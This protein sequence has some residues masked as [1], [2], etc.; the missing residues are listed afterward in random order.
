MLELE[1]KYV[2]LTA[3]PDDEIIFFGAALPYIKKIICCSNNYLDLSG[4]K[5]KQ[6]NSALKEIGQIIKTEIVCLDYDRNFYKLSTFHNGLYNFSQ[7]VLQLIKKEKI[8]FTHNFWG[9]YGNFDHIFIH[10]LAKTTCRKIITTDTCINAQIGEGHVEWFPIKQFNT[11]KDLGEFFFDANL[12]E[13]CKRVYESY[14][15][16]TWHLPM[17]NSVRLREIGNYPTRKITN[18]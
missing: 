5:H 3:H 14:K 16:W 4:K 15:C 13:E 9:E 18:V 12:Y 2:L 6:G 17:I 1:K 10:Q 11:G 8:I 7:E